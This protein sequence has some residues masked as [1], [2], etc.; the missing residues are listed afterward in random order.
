[1][2][3]MP[4]ITINE[5]NVNSL[6]YADGAVFINDEEKKLQII[7]DKLQ[8]VCM[9]YKVDS[10]VKKTKVLIIGKKD[11]ETCNI[12]VNGT[13]LK[14]VSKYNYLGSVITD[15]GG[16]EEDVKTRIAMAEEAF[17]QH[18]Q[19]FQ[20]NLKLSTKKIILV[21]YMSYVMKYTCEIWTNSMIL[22]T[23]NYAF[24]QWCYSWLTKISW[25]DKVKIKMY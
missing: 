2:E 22:E 12:V 10:N 5:Q 14:Q 1:M 17:W 20:V 11:E 13:T 9:E 15:S 6:R 8:E 19:L 24:Q 4:G 21:C 18:K 16:C 3:N 23:Q 7:L 25:K